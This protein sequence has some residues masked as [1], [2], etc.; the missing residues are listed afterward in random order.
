MFV[1]CLWASVFLKR[2]CVFDRFEIEIL[3][4]SMS[5][6]IGGEMILNWPL[7]CVR[8]AF[9]K[10][11]QELFEDILFSN[12]FGV[13]RNLK[14]TI[15]SLALLKDLLYGKSIFR[16]IFYARLSKSILFSWKSDHYFLL[17]IL[18]SLNGFHMKQKI[19]KIDPK[20]LV[21]QYLTCSFWA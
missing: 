13:H 6:W 4:R 8:F 19:F 21:G 15:H 10:N 5:R 11:S 7:K 12:F 3:N 16:W 14:E 1:D 17:I 20:I 18:L 2:H 9:H